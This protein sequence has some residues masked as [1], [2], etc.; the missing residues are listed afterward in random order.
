MNEGGH[1][2][3]THLRRL[4]D[5]V[6][7]V[8]RDLSLPAV[9]QRITET[10]VELVDARYGALG[11]LATDGNGLDEFISVGMDEDTVAAIG[12]P[13]EGHGILGLLIVDPKPLRLVDLRT[14]ADS[15]GFPPGH[16][17][18]TTF[19]GVPI[20]VAGQVYGNLYLTDKQSGKPFTEV[21]EELAVSF[22]AAAGVAI[23]NARLHSQLR[24]LD[25]VADRERIA[26]DLHDTVIQRLFA[27]ALSLQRVV[28]LAAAS[29]VRERVQ[30]A[31]EDLDVT[32]GQVRSAIFELQPQATPGRSLRR[33][34]LAVGGEMAGALGFDP[35]FRFEGAIDSLVPEAV[36]QHLLSVT[37]EALANAARHAH[38]RRVDV[39]VV[40]ANGRLCL[41]VTDDGVGPGTATGGRGIANLVARAHALGGD[42]SVTAGAARGTVVRWEIPLGP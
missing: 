6:M 5:A 38:A 12:P 21:D 14:H 7:D 40:V 36:G 28:K 24:E 18:M 33:E 13:P 26:R 22:A 19:L 16:P 11:V 23:D 10:A 41:T 1:A 8:G 32:I 15:Y 30:R 3:V 20:F 35:V 34:L 29:E 4:L 2:G 17:P 9:L 42:A 27:T 25:L 31:V 37:R 39:V